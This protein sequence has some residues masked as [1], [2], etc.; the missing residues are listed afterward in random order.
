M[1]E[2]DTL[3]EEHEALRKD[4]AALTRLIGPQLA[5]G[6]SDH[7]RIDLPA[8]EAA[9]ETLRRRLLEHE[10]KEER[11]ITR[12][13]RAPGAAEVEAEVERA[14]E[15]LNRLMELLH[16]AS[17]LCTEGRVHAL[18]TICGRVGEELESHL[19]YEETVLF[20]LL[21]GGVIT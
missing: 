16:S 5:V 10:A 19:R 18:R 3:L 12:R 11:F 21:K 4:A 2:L 9:R 17:A 14:H 13:L 8:F 20:P 7:A 15:T 1:S 6:W